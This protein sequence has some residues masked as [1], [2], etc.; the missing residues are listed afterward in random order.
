MSIADRAWDPF[1]RTLRAVSPLLASGD[2]KLARGIRGRR[3]AAERLREWA[4]AE[5]DP[6]RPCLWVH[7][8]SVGEGLQA[9]AVLEALRE[10]RPDVQVAFTWFSPSAEVLR[11]RLPVEVADYLP[12][13][14]HHEVAGVL[15]AISPDLVVFTKTE[16]WPGLTRA[17][18][19]RS[20]PVLLAAATL[21]AGSRRLRPGA[22]RLLRGTFGALDRVLAIAE[23]D[24]E[25][26]GALGVARDRVEITG[27]PGIDSAWKRSRE[28]DLSSP[29]LG[30]FLAA[31]VPTLVAGSTWE[32][33]EEVLIPALIRVAEG[34]GGSALR[35][36]IA[37][38]EP[39]EAHL[40]RL[41]AALGAHGIR[42]VRLAAVEEA[43]R[44]EPGH[45]VLVDRVGVLAH[46]YRVGTMA[47]V[48][49][50]FGTAGLHSVLEPAA[51]GS[52]VLFGPRHANARAAGEL[53]AAGG[54]RVIHDAAELASALLAWLEDEP[55][56]AD[57]GASAEGY[58]EQHRGAA[59][60]TASAWM[61]YL[62][63]RGERN[64]AMEAR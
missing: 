12:W 6:G 1:V 35:V 23:E 32:A 30:P 49:G 44:S 21:P 45:V 18:R 29:V 55:G 58:I 27:D 54:A 64:Q 53:E 48:G 15:D 2:S 7:A 56:R 57:A 5:R 46:L 37:P 10:T 31:R 19:E 36:I 26:F 41:E 43:G 28:A 13:D 34:A 22:R 59:A 63:P 20:I 25:R 3:G 4:V 14:A 52:P 50:G 16:A 33:D 38:H 42:A 51:A 39:D 17:A 24:G 11:G 61:R 60:R 9:R 40:R 47:Y 8:P 62:P